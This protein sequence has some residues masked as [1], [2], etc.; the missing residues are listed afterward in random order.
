M[1]TTEQLAGFRLQ[2]LKEK[3]EIKERLEQ[4]DHYG[5]ERAHYH[6]SMGELSSYDNHPA[7]EGTDLYEREKDIALN[8]HTDLQLLNINRALEAMENGTYGTC[9]VCGKE[10][11]FERLEALP[12][13][14][15]CKEH[16]PDQVV[17][18]DRP[19]EEG[20]LMPPFGKFDMDSKDENVA[21]DAEDS[22][23]I[24]SQWGTSDTPSDLA[25]P[26][27]HYND[28]NNE[29]DENEGYVEDFENFV[30]NDMYGNNITVYPNPQHERYEQSL[31]EE[32]IMTSFGDL[33]AYEHDPYVEDDK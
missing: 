1:L 28:V 19:I 8:Q 18:H 30:G 17:S 25:F 29:P 14:T 33:P 32:G 10:I 22:W 21:F 26:Q 27:E 13:T 20:V 15:Y 9:E 2:L 11:P 16:S 24:V 6:E 12:N 4:N 31:D 5:F 23:Q 7:D 3:D